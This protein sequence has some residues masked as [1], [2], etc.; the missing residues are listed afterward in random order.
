MTSK[1]SLGRPET[2]FFGFLRVTG[3]IAVLVGAVGSVGLMLYVGRRNESRILLILFALWV[4]SPF[5]ALV[6]ANVVSKRWPVHTPTLYSLMLVLTLGTLALY[7]DVAFWRPRPKPASVFLLVPPVSW[8][9]IAIA[10]LVSGRL[11][12]RSR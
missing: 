6:W 1:V 7:A 12:R 5:V 10:A 4:L 9:V 2:G 3:L 11:A 8:L